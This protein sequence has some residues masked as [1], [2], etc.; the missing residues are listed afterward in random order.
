MLAEPAGNQQSAVVDTM[1]DLPKTFT[2]VKV[3]LTN[4]SSNYWVQRVDQETA[5]NGILLALFNQTLKTLPVK[6]EIGQMCVGYYENHWYRVR[7]KT[8]KPQLTVHFVDY[9]NTETTTFDQLRQLP[10]SLSSEPDLAMRIHLA[11]GTSEQY[12]NKVENDLL[13]VKSVGKLKD[14]SILVHVEGEDYSTKVEKSVSNSSTELKDGSILVHVEGE[15]YST[16]VEKSVSNSSTE[17]KF[18]GNEPAFACRESGKPFRTPPLLPNLLNQ[19]LNLNLPI[20]CSLAQH[21]ISVLANSDTEDAAASPYKSQEL[22]TYFTERVVTYACVA[23]LPLM[24][25]WVN[26]IFVVTVQTE[27]MGAD[28][29]VANYH[30]PSHSHFTKVETDWPD[31]VYVTVANGPCD[32]W[33]QTKKCSETARNITLELNKI[34]SDCSPVVPKIGLAC[35]ALFMGDWY[36]GLVTS[37]S[38]QLKVFY[39]D[40][41]NTETCSLNDLRTLP[42]NLID[43]PSAAIRVQLSDGTPQEY[44]NLKEGKDISIKCVDIAAD[45]IAIV[46]VNGVTHTDSQLSPALSMILVEAGKSPAILTDK[47]EE[48]PGLPGKVQVGQTQKLYQYV[49][50]ECPYVYIKTIPVPPSVHNSFIE[51]VVPGVTGA[52]QILKLYS[53][54]FVA[55]I[56]TKDKDCIAQYELLLE[57]TKKGEKLPH[58]DNSSV[59]H[60]SFI[61]YVVPGVTGAL[62]ILK[63]YSN[64]FVASI[65]TKDKDC[66][67]QYELLL[68]L[69]KKGEKLPHFD[70]SSVPHVGDIVAAMLPSKGSFHRA[71]VISVEADGYMVNFCDQGTI[72]LVSFVKKLP[73]KY[74]CLPVAAI[75]CRVLTYL[76]PEEQFYL[77]YYKE[78]TSFLFKDVKFLENKK[79]CVLMDLKETP[80]CEIAMIPWETRPEVKQGLGKLPEKGDLVACQYLVDMNYYRARVFSIKDKVISVFFVDYGNMDTNVTLDMVKPLDEEFKK[81]PFMAF[82]FNM[83]YGSDYKVMPCLAN[84]IDTLV[85]N[86]VPLVLEF[87]PNGVVLKTED[88]VSVNEQ[89]KRMSESEPSF[90]ELNVADPTKAFQPPSSDETLKAAS[91]VN[92]PAQLI[93]VVSDVLMISKLPCTTVPVGEKVELHFLG[94]LKS[95]DIMCCKADKKQLDAVAKMLKELKEFYDAAP[96]H[97]HTPVLEELCIAKFGGS[98]WHRAVCLSCNHNSGKHNLLFLELGCVQDVSSDNIRKMVRDPKVLKIPSLAFMC[99]L[100]AQNSQKRK[101]RL[102][103]AV[104]PPPN[105]FQHCSALIF[106]PLSNNFPPTSKTQIVFSNAYKTLKTKP[107]SMRS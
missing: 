53:N 73:D 75:R 54:H 31:P 25:L 86:K 74:T 82:K 6:L 63:L 69:T 48:T 55:S 16:K 102:S 17:V 12:L 60:N 88:G 79:T 4:S 99:K 15:D 81:F 41:G 93:S 44:H 100:Q 28:D 61:E 19:N 21:E 85:N 67:A 64:H 98:D 70:N 9:G 58:F 51:Y 8:L 87:H 37:L 94:I 2:Q 34:V 27:S 3:V 26:L 84:Y 83:A 89:I 96:Q 52:L 24:G 56:A 35:S 13:T 18:R 42:D 36:R 30:Q 11:E 46:H 107:S 43:I 106:N 33:V 95:M 91:P 32:Y 40:Y 104:G 5:L 77:E 66:I 72:K 71:M 10:E 50:S 103:L 23:R 20:L 38:P 76:I 29:D 92:T 45:G 1:Q 65:A 97:P 14:G 80:L 68:E 7:V 62:Q 22:P 105:A 39:V 90:K 78:S 59:V 57:L 49:I 101:A 47:T